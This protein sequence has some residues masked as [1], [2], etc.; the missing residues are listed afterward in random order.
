MKMSLQTH[1]YLVSSLC[2]F[3]VLLYVLFFSQIATNINYIAYDDI[4]VLQI[5]EQCKNATNLSQILDYLTIGFPEHHIVFTRLIVLLMY[6]LTGKVNLVCLMVVGNILLGGQLWVFYQ[7]FRQIRLPIIYF[8]PFC[9]ILINVH[10]FENMFW[11]TSSVGNFG[12]LFFVALSAYLYTHNIAKNI[13][14]ALL[15]S[16]MA[17]FTYGNGLLAFFIGTFILT[18][19]RQWHHL[20][21]TTIVLVV[22]IGFYRLLGSNSYPNELDLTNLKNYGLVLASFFGFLGASVNLSYQ[23]Y[24]LWLAVV[25]GAVL[26]G[27]ILWFLRQLWLPV[28]KMKWFNVANFN[29]AQ[30]F[31]LFLFLFVCLSALGVAYKRLE[32]DGFIG[33]FKVRYSVYSAWLLAVAYLLWATNLEQQ[34]KP[35]LALI[36]FILP[37]VIAFNLIVFY[38]SVAPAVNARRAALAQE[39]NSVSNPDWIGLQMFDMTQT[40]FLDTRKLYSPALFFEKPAFV[41]QLS[42]TAPMRKWPL[43]SLYWKNGNLEIIW[44]KDFIRPQKDL[45]DGAYVL[46]KS[47]VHSYMAAGQQQKVPLKTFIRRGWYWDRGFWCSFGKNATA[48]DLYQVYV[49]IRQNGVNQI[50]DTDRRVRF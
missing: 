29:A 25:W 20:F 30:Q 1:R 42:A 2:I 47:S 44:G 21:K 32:N 48:P 19:T 7:V 6:A 36:R 50:Y 11:G 40:Q 46:L 28:F 49:L 43:D 37:I 9:W 4:V 35:K 8:V 3:P 18:L 26:F 10:S 15:C 16:T 31:A 22:V 39:F 33:M 17:T 23:P 5:V 13:N 38:Y 27:I 14:W 34:K 12:V 24:E 45:D 41:G